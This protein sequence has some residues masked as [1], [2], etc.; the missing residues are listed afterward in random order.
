MLL[1]IK[2]GDAAS[3][4]IGNYF[5]TA[6]QIPDINVATINLPGSH[7]TTVSMAQR[8][9][10]TAD[11]SNYIQA[12]G[13]AGKINYI[14]LSSGFPSK[15]TDS[16][17]V[18]FLDV[19]LMHKLSKIYPTGWFA[20]NPYAYVRKSNYTNRADIKFSREKYGYYI[21]SR[22]D[23]PS[24]YGIKKM[25]DNFGPSVF[26]TYTT[27]MK[28]IIDSQVQYQANTTAAE[29]HQENIRANIEARGGTFVLWRTNDG[30]A[31]DIDNISFLDC[32]W[33]IGADN[34]YS[35]GSV[36]ANYPHQWKRL[37]FK[38]GSLMQAYRSFPTGNGYFTTREQGLHSYSSGTL[39]SVMA[40][41]GSDF[42]YNN[43]A[44]ITVNPEDHTLWCAS[45]VRA[46]H[47]GTSSYDFTSPDYESRNGAGIVVY[48]KSGTV[49]TRY[50]KENTGGGLLCNA[51]FT[52]TYDKYNHR[53]WVGG[54]TGVSY[55]N[56]ITKTWHTPAGLSHTEGARVLQI[57]VDPTTAGTNVYVSFTGGNNQSKAYNKLANWTRVFE[58]NTATGTTTARTLGISG[59]IYSPFMVK[60]APDIMWLRYASNNTVTQQYLRK[61]QLSTDT[62]LHEISFA[63]IDGM[64]YRVHVS[65]SSA[66]A[67]YHNVI[68]DASSGTTY[69]Y[70]PIASTNA[71][72]TVKNAVLRITDDGSSYIKQIWGATNWWSAASS[73]TSNISAYKLIQNP[74]HPEK[75]YL[76]T[77]ERNVM[78]STGGKVIEFS[79]ANTNGTELKAGS[80][81]LININDAVFDDQ[82]DGKLWFV[83]YQY[84]YTGQYALYELFNYG[85]TGAMG[86][87]THDSFYYDGSSLY[88]STTTSELIA[89]NLLDYHLYSAESGG[90]PTQMAMYQMKGMA[91]LLL[92]GFYFAESRFGS[93]ASYPIQGNG[94]H[95]S[96]MLV[97]DPKAAPYAPRVD[98]AGTSG[99]IT[100][101]G[102]EYR[103]SVKLLVPMALPTNR[104]FIAS[105][106]T[107]S[108]VKLYDASNN[109]MSAKSVSYDSGANVITYVTESPI[110][111][112][113]T[114]KLT[115]TCGINGIKC[116]TGASLVN[117]RAAEFRDDVSVDVSLPDAT[118]PI[119]SGAPASFITNKSFIVTLSVDDNYGYWSTNGSAYRSFPASNTNITIS[120]TTVLSY[121]GKDISGNTSVTNT[122]TYTFDTNAPVITGL[123]ASFTT[124]ASFSLSLGLNEN[125]GYWSTNG[126]VTYNP[127]TTNGTV[128]LFTVSRT[129]YFYTSDA[130]SN[131]SGTNTRVYTIGAGL[132]NSPSGLTATA[133][134][135]TIRLS[136]ADTATNET[137]FRIYRSTNNI[138]FSHIHSTAAG[139]TSYN[140]NSLDLDTRYYYRVTATNAIGESSPASA[141]TVTRILLTFADC[142]VKTIPMKQSIVVRYTFTKNC[143]LPAMA[144]FFY[145]VSG[146]TNFIPCMSSAMTLPVNG[147]YSNEMTLSNA[148]RNSR[149]DIRITA[150]IGT[151]RSAYIISNIDLTTWFTVSSNIAD[152]CAVNN[153]YRGDGYVSFVNITAATTAVIFSISGKHIT[154]LPAPADGS[155][156]LWNATASDGTKVAPGVYLCILTSATDRKIVKVMVLRH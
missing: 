138:S 129:V 134:G 103:C 59:T 63:N 6:R 58:H 154:S 43:M 102:S 27:G 15:G 156:I 19:Y 18:S 120:G 114:Y 91:M 97:M 67:C 105:T 109:L 75:I 30:F 12:N 111:A 33:V 53:M 95:Y 137:A 70:T 16:A 142:S 151:N 13:L 113:Q 51:V 117:T 148:D 143:A 150:T 36:I 32:D 5:K 133:E 104:Q 9:Q 115:L 122:R 62:A 147:S 124:N 60:T 42:E 79:A 126:G 72:V 141:D 125:T 65:W 152:A 86:G 2:S 84:N 1:I 94:G 66:N 56:L 22:L 68:A 78:R 149:Y 93:L 64:D 44:G 98:F 112:L 37:S 155:R 135:S 144:D 145:A 23:G 89:T 101:T 54:F 26:D 40:A 50:T 29:Q 11:I 108:T 107:S 85:L 116:V 25:I 39:T 57:Y 41:D 71:S 7:G 46:D 52:I 4:E 140:D 100:R 96:H 90:Y 87:F 28:Y 48:D 55:F 128:L 131:N 47:S 83:R 80:S 20:N 127:F 99:V 74:L 92:D 139:T 146:S 8:D 17:G 153:P 31:H 69:I 21:V 119:V 81:S 34:T 38:P 45:S 10:F 121:F 3:A 49:I 77:R 106:I 88:G 110:S 123:P 82:T 136:W 73:S 61:I 132:P 24:K 35:R 118:A 14:V 130:F 76:I